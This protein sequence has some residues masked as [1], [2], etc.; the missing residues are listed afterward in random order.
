MFIIKINIKINLDNLI[1]LQCTM[2]SVNL[3]Y[4][5]APLK[6][7]NGQIHGAEINAVL[8]LLLLPA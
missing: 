3:V 4:Y 1:R 5:N 6:G 2:L 7:H 8:L